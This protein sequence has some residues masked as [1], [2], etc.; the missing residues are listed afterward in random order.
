MWFC[1]LIKSFLGGF[2]RKTGLALELRHPRLSVSTCVCLF[3]FACIHI[4]GAR[5]LYSNV[6]YD[7][8]AKKLLNIDI[9]IKGDWKIKPDGTYGFIH[10]NKYDRFAHLAFGILMFL[11]VF[12]MV[13]RI[14]NGDNTLL[15]ILI[16]WLTI[17]TFSMLYPV[18]RKD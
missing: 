9:N 3:I 6:P 7:E 4:L 11:P 16:A 8:W 12:Q 14:V 17:Q 5:Y 10:G 18:F 15:A 2:L 13:K 1:H